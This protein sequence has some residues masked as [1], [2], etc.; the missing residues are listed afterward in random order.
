MSQTTPTSQLSYLWTLTRGHRTVLSTSVALSLVAAV[1]TVLQP[2]AMQRVINLATDGGSFREP[3]V[4]LVLLV[5]GATLVTALQSYTSLRGAESV[6]HELRSRISARYIGMTVAEADSRRSADLVSRA[7]NDTS[8]VKQLVAAGLLPLLGSLVMLVGI[9]VVMVLIDPWLFALSIGA[10]LVGFVIVAVVAGLANRASLLIQTRT[11]EFS[12]AVERTL[13]AL[14]TVKANNGQEQEQANIV[15]RSAELRD[16]GFSLARLSSFVQPTLNLCVQGA[17]LAVI[18]VGAYRLT[19]GAIDLGALLAYIMYMFMLI[20]PVASL[21]QAY[22][23]MQVGFGAIKR[24]QEM[25]TV[26]A[27]RTGGAWPAQERPRPLVELRDV[28]FAYDPATPVLT[29]VDLTVHRGDRLT[30]VG[31]SGSGK[32]TV[33][34]LIQGF[35]EPDQGEVRARGLPLQEIDLRRHRSSIALVQQEASVMTGTLRDNLQLARPGV[36]DEEMLDALHRVGLSAVV[37]RAPE[38]L[39]IDLGQSGV[40]LSSGQRQ[41]IAWARVLLSDAELVLMDEPDSNLDTAT[42]ALVHEL[43]DQVAEERTV[44][45]VSHRLESVHPQDRIVVMAEGRVVAEGTHA[46]LLA[47]SAHYRELAPAALQAA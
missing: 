29:G 21:G 27:E 8:V 44:V 34:E 28:S 6:A 17:L 33:L 38:G 23:T 35:Y 13:A 45:V 24:C 37:Q 2:Q 43:L 40:V 11:G 42:R 46:E 7:A 16:S 22:A 14:R 26:D 10:F 32:S 1:L 36:S 3:L 20:V 15:R 31:R 12:V 18:L 39:D 9:A 4:L 25:D 41:R 19:T 30:V 5:V 47:T